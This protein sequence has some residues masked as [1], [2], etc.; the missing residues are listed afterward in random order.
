MAK[1][2]PDIVAK[3]FMMQME[4]F[5]SGEEMSEEFYEL[6]QRIAELARPPAPIQKR[7]KPLSVAT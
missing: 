4:R 7:F 1:K 3:M 5:L 2:E 6:L